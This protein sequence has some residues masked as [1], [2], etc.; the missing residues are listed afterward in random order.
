[1]SHLLIDKPEREEIRLRIEGDDVKGWVGKCGLFIVS[2]CIPCG[3]NYGSVGLEALHGHVAMSGLHRVAASK[4]EE[5]TKWIYALESL[6]AY[7]SK[8]I[9]QVPTI[10]PVVQVTI[11]PSSSRSS[12][13]D[14][15]SLL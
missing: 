8:A 7:K 2:G 1:M 6:P 11:L 14:C 3:Q 9:F 13:S 4:E 15:Q 5:I 12:S 10:P